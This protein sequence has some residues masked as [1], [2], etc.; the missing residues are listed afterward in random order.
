MTEAAHQMASNPVAAP[1]RFAGS[2]G[3]AAGPEIAIMGPRGLAPAW[4]D[5]EVVIRGTNVT[6]GYDGNSKAN[7]QSF[8]GGWF[9]TGDQGV[10]DGQGYLRLTGRLKEI[11][12]RGGEKISPLE[13]DKVLMEHPAV[14]QAVTFGMPTKVGRGSRRGRG[15]ARGQIRRR[16]SL[17][18]LRGRTAGA[19]SKCRAKWFSDGNSQGRDWKT[20][21]HRPGRKARPGFTNFV[22]GGR[23]MRLR[24]LGRSTLRVAPLCLGG[25]VFGWTADEAASFAVLDAFV[26]PA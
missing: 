23:P 9:H 20:S 26:R 22:T 7:E 3:V 13:I 17:A 10:L 11:I 6:K 16:E 12:N 18:R 1:A 24:A 21:A 15:P 4:L 5:G 2:V 14:Q 8:H 25:N 19:N